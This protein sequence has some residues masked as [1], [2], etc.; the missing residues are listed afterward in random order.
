MSG[1][2]RRDN[3]YRG[4]TAVRMVSCKTGGGQF[5]Q[6]ELCAVVGF[7]LTTSRNDN[8]KTDSIEYKI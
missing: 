3:I 5:I 6:A 8:L 1:V 7:P 4:R 2:P